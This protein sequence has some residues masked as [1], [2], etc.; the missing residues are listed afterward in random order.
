[1]LVEDEEDSELVIRVFDLKEFFPNVDV[2]AFKQALRWTFQI[3]WEANS[4]W[5][6][7]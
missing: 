6:W 1:M 5:M 2:E 4:S 3:V 7:F